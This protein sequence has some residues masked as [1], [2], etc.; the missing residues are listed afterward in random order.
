MLASNNKILTRDGLVELINDKYIEFRVHDHIRKPQ[1]DRLPE[2]IN[3]YKTLCNGNI[4][5]LLMVAN[6]ID[7]MDKEEEVIIRETIPKFFNSQAIVTSNRFTIM[8][9]NLAL[10]FKKPSV[11]T[12][13]FSSEN[14]AL[15]WLSE[16]IDN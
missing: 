4:Y 6:H 16:F 12:K 5:P 11:P 10:S 9:I 13:I 3:A 14:K 7:R 15:E 2:I 1:K 8:V